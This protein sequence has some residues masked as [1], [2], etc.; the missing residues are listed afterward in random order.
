MRGFLTTGYYLH[1]ITSLPIKFAKKTQKG[2]DLYN[3][4]GYSYIHRSKQL[5]TKGNEM[6]NQY[7][8]TKMLMQTIS[9]VVASESDWRADFE[10][11]DLESWLGN[12]FDDSEWIA[13][14]YL[15]EVEKY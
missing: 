3:R 13:A 2:L 10:N 5:K 4:Q 8:E 7:K 9:G 6:S 15:V 11:M 1:N 14:G 12:D